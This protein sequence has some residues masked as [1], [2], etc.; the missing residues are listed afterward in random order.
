MKIGYACINTILNKEGIT[1]N[2]DMIKRTFE[3]K[4]ILYASELALQNAKDLLPIL[5]WNKQNNIFLFR[6]SSNIFPW[7]SQYKL[8]DLPDYEEI[9]NILFEAGKFAKENNMRITCHPDHFVKLASKKQEVVN[10]S[11][12]DLEM[13]AQVFNLMGLSKTPF[14]KI[15]IHIGSGA[16]DLYASS[17]RFVENLSRLSY[18]VISRLTIENDDKPNLFTTQML[19]DWVYKVMDIP[20]VFDYHH[21]RIN[22]GGMSEQEALELAISTWGNIVPIVHYS[23]SRKIN[24]DSTCNVTAH[25]DYIY[26]KINT[27]TYDIDIMLEAKM[28]EQAVKRY[29]QSLLL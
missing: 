7:N 19:Y 15:N 5:K 10:N 1:T 20:I 3:T 11:I 9:S 4:G 22:N 6:L 27:Y 13:H 17:Q 21:H 24:E 2:R 18:D 25:A 8:T 26:E 28:K 14:N 23:S 29:E 16:D 12:Y